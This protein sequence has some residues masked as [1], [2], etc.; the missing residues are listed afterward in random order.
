MKQTTAQINR[1]VTGAY[2]ALHFL[3]DMGLTRHRKRLFGMAC[4]EERAHRRLAPNGHVWPK[5]AGIPA[6]ARFF[7]VK[8][9]AGAL[10]ATG[11]RKAVVADA[12]HWQPS[13]FYAASIVANYGAEILRAWTGQDIAALADLDYVAFVNNGE[14]K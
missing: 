8:R 10:T 2:D 7:V 13:A 12:I 1:M 6:A 11:D 5:G 4:D 9:I 3:D 14:V